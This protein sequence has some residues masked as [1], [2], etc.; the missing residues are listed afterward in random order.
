[1]NFWSPE[2]WVGTTALTPTDVFNKVM[3]LKCK[4]K[5]ETENKKRFFL[6]F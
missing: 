5:A 6:P 3:I 1:M 4:L 2:Q